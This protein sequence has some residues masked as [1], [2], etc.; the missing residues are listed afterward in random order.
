MLEAL[1]LRQELFCDAVLCIAVYHMH[2]E[3]RL[4]VVWR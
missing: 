4:C 3:A 2:A 1:A